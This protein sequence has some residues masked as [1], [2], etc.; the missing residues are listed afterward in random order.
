M[1]VKTL[2]TFF[3]KKENVIRKVG[4]EF[5]CSQDRFEEINKTAKDVYNSIFV[6]ALEVK[7]KAAKSASKKVNE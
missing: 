4:D 5:E 7:K 3:D 2:D 1:R 6:E